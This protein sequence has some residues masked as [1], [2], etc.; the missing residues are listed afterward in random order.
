MREG[1]WAE[2]SRKSADVKEEWSVKRRK[3]CRKKKWEGWM[4]WQFWMGRSLRRIA[5]ASLY[6]APPLHPSQETV[7]GSLGCLSNQNGKK[8][9]CVS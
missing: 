8:S 1:M 5:L 4:E 2:T 6:H 7:L 9:L 3:Q